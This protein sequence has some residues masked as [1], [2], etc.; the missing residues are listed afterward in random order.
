MPA[1][2]FTHHSHSLATPPISHGETYSLLVSL[3]AKKYCP[4]ST[5]SSLRSVDLLPPVLLEWAV[6]RS[7][8]FCSG[9]RASR[10][11]G[12]SSG[13]PWSRSSPPRRRRVPTLLDSV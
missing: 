13:Y 7:T 6:G 2:L 4:I 10:D 12:Y 8:T 11:S 5:T 9:G 1:Q 3:T